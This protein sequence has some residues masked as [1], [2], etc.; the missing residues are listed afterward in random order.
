[1]LLQ[2]ENLT[3][4]QIVSVKIHYLMNHSFQ[5]LIFDFY[6]PALTAFHT[7]AIRIP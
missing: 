6:S 2:I 4:F 3:L 7:F 1:M 5:N